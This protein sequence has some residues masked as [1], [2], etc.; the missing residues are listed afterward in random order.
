MSSVRV[1]HLDE[2]ECLTEED[3]RVKKQTFPSYRFSNNVQDWVLDNDRE[4]HEPEN[5]KKSPST[6]WMTK[7]ESC[8][9]GFSV[10]ESRIVRRVEVRDRRQHFGHRSTK[11]FPAR[12]SREIGWTSDS[13]ASPSPFLN[14]DSLMK[15]LRRSSSLTVLLDHSFAI[16]TPENTSSVEEELCAGRNYQLETCQPLL[17]SERRDRDLKEKLIEAQRVQNQLKEQLVQTLRRNQ[18]TEADL[19]SRLDQQ[20]M[21]NQHLRASDVKFKSMIYILEE[22]MNKFIGWIAIILKNFLR[23][24]RAWKKRDFFEILVALVFSWWS[25]DQRMNSTNTRALLV[26]GFIRGRNECHYRVTRSITIRT[27]TKSLRHLRW[28]LSLKRLQWRRTR[29]VTNNET[30]WSLMNWSNYLP[31][32][33][34]TKVIFV[35][36]DNRRKRSSIR[37]R[38]RQ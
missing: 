17:Q 12:S 8:W 29:G 2:F 14:N 19:T 21:L 11:C 6:R 9:W 20:K 35:Y 25:V 31:I 30:I 37:R 13:F 7:I 3:E 38:K 24:T 34:L 33:I 23:R 26:D 28:F 36:V 18:Q 15:M 1:I 22:W 32:E 27:S 5:P 10:W 16:L 4:D